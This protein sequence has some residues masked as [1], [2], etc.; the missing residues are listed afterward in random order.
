MYIHTLL[1]KSDELCS[2]AKAGV[3][4]KVKKLIQLGVYVDSTNIVSWL[5]IRR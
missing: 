1:Q 5:C 4:T 3:V 2:A